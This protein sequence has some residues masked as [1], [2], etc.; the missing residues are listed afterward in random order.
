MKSKTEE[1]YCTRW[2]IE[3]QYTAPEE[4]GK[5]LCS[6]RSYRPKFTLTSRQITQVSL[7]SPASTSIYP[8]PGTT[9]MCRRFQRRDEYSMSRI[10]QQVQPESNRTAISIWLS[11]DVL[12]TSCV[13][14][15]RKD[16]VGSKRELSPNRP[17]QTR[18]LVCFSSR[19]K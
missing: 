19:L 10:H 1:S 4:Q 8:R 16:F 13:P 11:A 18:P 12:R 7:W 6:P 9:P 5:T 17:H 14:S 3:E 2:H 15:A